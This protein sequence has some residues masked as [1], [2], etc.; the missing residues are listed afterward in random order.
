MAASTRNPAEAVIRFEGQ[1]DAV[2]GFVP[3]DPSRRRD[4]RVF[5][6]TAD[7]QQEVRALTAPAGDSTLVRL[8]LPPTVAAGEADAVVEI[9]ELRVPATIVIAQRIEL[10]CTPS[11]LDLVVAGKEAT[12]ALRV[13][14][15]GNA[16]VELPSIAAFGLMSEGG[17]ETAIGAGLTG[18]R[19]GV[20][21][22]GD[23]ADTLA[24]RHGGLVRV[25]IRPEQSYLAPGEATDVRLSVR[26]GGSA[27]PG[28][29]YIGVLRILNLKLGVR[30]RI[31]P[32]S[33]PGPRA[34]RKRTPTKG[35]SS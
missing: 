14:N 33:T 27:R 6:S 35:A 8:V 32:E 28:Q 7:G 26:P 13:V 24:D 31:E 19:S 15:G 1:P 21:R 3:V 11:Q 18:P 29:Q 25:A 22:L 16:G 30:L 17:L 5:V 12:V 4:V 20:D 23:V 34:P 9:G 2:E 10:L